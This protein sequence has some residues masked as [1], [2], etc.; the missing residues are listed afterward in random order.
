MGRIVYAAAMS[1]G[2]YPDYHGQNVGPHG[3]RMAKIGL[4][5]ESLLAMVDVLGRKTRLEAIHRA[6]AALPMASFSCDVLQKLAPMLAVTT[7]TGV[8]WCDW[9]SLRRVLQS[10]EHLS[11][12]PPWLARLTEP[13]GA[14]S[15]S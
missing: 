10:L 1:H 13:V 11:I 3:R 8:T 6:S 14:G 12:R 5:R 2:L 7:L 15:E 9:G 4:Y